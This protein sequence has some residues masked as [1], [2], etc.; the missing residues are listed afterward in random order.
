[1]IVLPTAKQLII[2]KC[3]HPFILS[4]QLC[5]SFIF[6][7]LY[8]RIVIKK[9]YFFSLVSY[10]NGCIYLYDIYPRVL[11][12]IFEMSCIP[13]QTTSVYLSFIDCTA[14]LLPYQSIFYCPLRIDI[15][16]ST[17]SE[18]NAFL[19]SVFFFSLKVNIIIYASIDA[20]T[21]KKKS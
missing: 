13:I 9:S 16:C 10:I 12:H 4:T 14:I 20:R 17:K 15:S 18:K 19:Q 21:K 2:C 1:M 5:F 11:M 7:L 6:N 8:N 3:R